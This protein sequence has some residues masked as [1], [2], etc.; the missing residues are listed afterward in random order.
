MESVGGGR[1]RECVV[2]TQEACSWM[3][4]IHEIPCLEDPFAFVY[5]YLCTTGLLRAVAM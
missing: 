1:G 5:L 2:Q 3:Y 4:E